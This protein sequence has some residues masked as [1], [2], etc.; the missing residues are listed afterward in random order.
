MNEFNLFCMMFSNVF[1]SLDIVS[2]ATNNNYSW[3]IDRNSCVPKPGS[4]LKLFLSYP[5][6]FF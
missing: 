4:I 5:T 2:E 6:Q 3:L 1:R